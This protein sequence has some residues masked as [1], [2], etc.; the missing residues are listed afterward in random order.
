MLKL[1]ALGRDLSAYYPITFQILFS[2]LIY[3]IFVSQYV[4]GQVRSSP[5]LGSANYFIR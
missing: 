5:Y 1:T 2:E 4:C 3:C